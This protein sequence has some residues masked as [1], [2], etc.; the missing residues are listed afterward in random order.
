MFMVHFCVHLDSSVVD[1]FLNY[2]KCV[3]ISLS[4]LRMFLSNI[5]QNNLKQIC[6]MNPHSFTIC[7]TIRI[8][9]QNKARVLK[10]GVCEAS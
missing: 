5:F 2:A 7:T 8:R 1:T 9:Y 4:D 3:Q 6:K 10:Q